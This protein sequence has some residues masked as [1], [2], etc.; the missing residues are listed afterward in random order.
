MDI[1][2]INGANTAKIHPRQS[3]GKND[4]LNLLVTQLRYQNPLKPMDN[5]EFIAQMAQFSSLEQMQNLNAGFNSLFGLKQLTAGSRLIGRTIE[6]RDSKTGKPVTG[7]VS[8]VKVEDDVTKLVVDSHLVLLS[9]IEK[10][11][12]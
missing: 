8:A 5:S 6:G 1:S 3:L 10:I 4:F 7:I 12:G 2:A 9:D 11:T